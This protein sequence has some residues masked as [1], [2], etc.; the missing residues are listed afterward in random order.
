MARISANHGDGHKFALEQEYWLQPIFPHVWV[1]SSAAC[2]VAKEGQI[3][4]CRDPFKVF[5]EDARGLV[6]STYANG[7]SYSDTKELL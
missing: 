5:G 4:Q 6:S 1:P 3:N 2:R 7:E